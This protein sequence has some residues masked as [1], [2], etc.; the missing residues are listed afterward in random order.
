MRQ[1]V[2][3][4]WTARTHEEKKKSPYHPT[5][6]CWCLHKSLCQQ[7]SYN[8]AF[9]LSVVF[10]S[11]FRLKDCVMHP[12]LEELFQVRLPVTITGITVESGGK[13][14]E[15]AYLPM[16]EYKGVNKC[17]LITNDCTVLSLKAHSGAHLKPLN[18]HRL[19]NEK[20]ILE[21]SKTCPEGWFC[22]AFKT[23]EVYL[24]EMYLWLSSIWWKCSTEC[25]L[26]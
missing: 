6:F 5:L 18:E 4:H 1:Y 16:A 13:A 20:H 12:V 14:L 21:S 8:P 23:I 9:F 25:H 22:P 19:I 7:S 11:H 24:W 2:Q 15:P 17:S 3:L 10:V 26:I